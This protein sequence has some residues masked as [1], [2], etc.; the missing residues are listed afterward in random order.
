[1]LIIWHVRML[2]LWI[3]NWALNA[4]SVVYFSVSCFGCLLFLIFV[5]HL[6]SF[7]FSEIRAANLSKDCSWWR[8]MQRGKVQ[9]FRGQQATCIKRRAVLSLMLNPSFGGKQQEAETIVN[10]VFPICSEDWAPFQEIP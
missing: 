3:V 7:F 6:L 4:F 9:E 1:M 5:I 8:E 2:Y 10:D